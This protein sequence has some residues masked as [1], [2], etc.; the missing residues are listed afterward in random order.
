MSCHR[1]QGALDVDES[2]NLSCTECGESQGGVFDAFPQYTSKNHKTA[3]K[4]GGGK[5]CSGCGENC[6]VEDGGLALVVCTGCGVVNDNGVI[7]DEAD[8]N[9]YESTRESG[10]DNSRV[11]WFDATNPYATLGS[12]IKSGKNSYIKVC[13]AEGKW[14]SRDLAK[15][16]QIC[17]ANSK[18]KS[19][20][21]VIKK[22]NALTY[23]NAFNQRTVDR[24]KLFWNQIVKK[25]R[26]FRGGNRNGIIACC[27]LYAC[28]DVNVPTDRETISRHMF[29]PMDDIVKGEPIFKNII[30]ETRFRDV[31][32]KIPD[33]SNNFSHT[34]HKLGLPYSVSGICQ[35]VFKECEEELSEISTSSATGGVITFVVT[36]IL[37]QKK[38]SKK[39]ISEIIGI[40][41]P[42]ITNS[43][44]IINGIVDPSKFC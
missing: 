8:W 24:A 17:S 12:M 20:Y 28:Y 31:L 1:C 34:I 3:A 22:L 30:Q 29:I 42:T 39:E 2:G 6:L 38:P 11:G 5:K 37:K 32:Q 14:V 4:V 27:V 7:A 25:D 19:F 18:E 33:V 26:I 16:N 41:V 36:R 15:L 44:K 43:V 21:E 10:K 13:N 23:D 35:S 9:N 40:S